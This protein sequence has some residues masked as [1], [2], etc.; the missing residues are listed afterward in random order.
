M[1]I[2]VSPPSEQYAVLEDVDWTTYTRLLRAFEHRRRYR[3]TY[4][5]GTLVIM[6]LS[7]QHEHSSHLL[8]RF[9]IVLTEELGLPVDGGKSTTFRRRRLKRGLEAD[10]CYWIAHEAQVRGK[11][12]INLRTDPP[13]DLALEIVITHHPLD[14]MTIYAKLKVPE[15]WQSDGKTVTFHVLGSDGQYCV[16]PRSLAFPGLSPGDLSRFM[17][18]CGQ[19]EENTI[20]REFRLWVRQQISAG[21]PG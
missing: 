18:Q 1:S 17:A 3:F 13:P 8:G 5:R 2:A 20:V 10:E 4:D 11:A 19:V 6:T 16:A 21:W 12:R 9:V 14:R 7:H 15:V